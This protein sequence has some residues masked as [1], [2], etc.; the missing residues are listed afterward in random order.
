MTIS[1][2]IFVLCTERIGDIIN[3][4]VE[5]GRWKPIRLSRNGPNPSHLFFADDLILFV[6]T[7]V[8]LIIIVMECLNLF[9]AMSGQRISLQKSNIA[10]SKGVHKEE[11]LEISSVA[12]I[13]PTSDLGLYLGT[14]TIHG[15][16]G[17]GHFQ[18]VLA[19]QVNS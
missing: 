16:V 1:P 17:L 14:P 12:G 6:E 5:E 18:Q 7:S 3:E 19:R 13:P 11:A 4:V 2:Y 15:R 9:C 8:E 10:F